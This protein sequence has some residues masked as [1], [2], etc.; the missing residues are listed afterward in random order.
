MTFTGVVN[1]GGPSPEPPSGKYP[2]HSIQIVKESARQK[3][4]LKI[5][6]GAKGCYVIIVKEH[7]F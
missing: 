3:A 2:S 7:F 4:G 6:S 5:T 1:P